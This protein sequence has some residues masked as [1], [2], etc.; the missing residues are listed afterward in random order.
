MWDFRTGVIPLLVLAALGVWSV[1]LG[2]G[3]SMQAKQMREQLNMPEKDEME[4]AIHHKSIA[5]CFLLLIL[6]LSV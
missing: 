3:G 4:R 5:A 1:W 6:V 2:R